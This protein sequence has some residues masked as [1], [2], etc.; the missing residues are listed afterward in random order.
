MALQLKQA[1]INAGLVTKDK[2]K[3]LEKEKVKARHL[4]E[5]KKMRE[6]QLRIICEV[7]GKSAPDV[8]RYSHTN[9]LIEGKAWLCL[10]CADEHRIDD[11]CRL[12]NQSPQA[13]AK[14]FRRE[15]GRTKKFE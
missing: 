12:T 4:K 1:L 10:R 15:Y 14:L 8:E 7:C 5:G 6:D 11:E 9:K 2:L 3:E 13:K